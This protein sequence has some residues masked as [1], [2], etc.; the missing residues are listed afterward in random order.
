M[1]RILIIGGLGYC[2][3]YLGDGLR[4]DGHEIH[5]TDLAE[6]CGQD[7]RALLP[8][9]LISYDSVLWFAGASSVAM[10]LANPEEALDQNFLGLLRLRRSLPPS[11]Y[12]IYASSASVY[13]TIDPAPT[14]AGEYAPIHPGENVYD[15]SKFLVDY[16]NQGGWLPNSLGL[17]MGTVCGW[18]NPLRVDTIFNKMSL[19]ALECGEISVSGRETWRAILFLEDLLT[20]VRGCLTS[21]PT[22]VL[23][24][25]SYNLT[26]G[27]IAEILGFGYGVPVVGR[28]GWSTYN[29]RLDSTEMRQ[30][31]RIPARKLLD[32]CDIFRGK[33]MAE[34]GRYEISWPPGLEQPWV[35]PAEARI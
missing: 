35:R 33:W 8:K 6:P 28:E 15:R 3:S 14:P 31:A 32:Q 9:D 24:A 20:L 13:S 4:A 18:N 12:L 10:A 26:I 25:F 23:N 27:N 5:V 22:G 34:V 17:R 7:Y 21:R 29:F 16:T 1:A 11:T 19:D 30:V 2:G